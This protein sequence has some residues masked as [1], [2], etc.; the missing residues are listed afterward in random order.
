VHPKKTMQPLID[1]INEFIAVNHKAAEAE[2]SQ[3][4]ATTRLQNLLT[5][6][7]G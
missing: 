6:L 1:S 7:Q 3:F 4:G 5:M 2:Q